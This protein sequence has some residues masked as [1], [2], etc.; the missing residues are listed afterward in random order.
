MAIGVTVGLFADILIRVCDYAFKKDKKREDLPSWPT[1][2]LAARM[3][4]QFI[5]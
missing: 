5:L 2:I 3:S 4:L 1:V